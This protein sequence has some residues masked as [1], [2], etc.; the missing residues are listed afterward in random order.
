MQRRN[1]AEKVSLDILRVSCSLEIYFGNLAWMFQLRNLAGKLSL[2][3]L[4]RYLA[5]TFSLEFQLRN[6]AWELQLE[7]SLEISLDSFSLEIQIRHLAGEIS[8]EHELRDS[9]QKLNLEIQLLNLGWECQ[10]RNLAWKFSLGIIAQNSL[11]RTLAGKISLAN[12]Q[13][14]DL[15]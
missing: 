10:L 13:L 7:N 4:L 1:L 11:L 2:V 14:R 12:Q 15:A 5:Y 9:A 8:L 3:N 6:L